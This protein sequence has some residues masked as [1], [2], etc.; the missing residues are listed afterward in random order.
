MKQNTH[1]PEAI[2]RSAN[3]IK[4]SPDALL[5]DFNISGYGGFGIEYANY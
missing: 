3:N 2:N 5:F 1:N 4:N